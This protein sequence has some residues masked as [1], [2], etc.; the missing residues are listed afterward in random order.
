MELFNSKIEKNIEIL[1]LPIRVRPEKLQD[2]VGQLHLLGEKKPLRKIIESD[3]IP[4]MVFYGPPGCGKTALA[5]II[6]NMTKKKFVSLNAVT[7]T[8]SD[9]RDVLKEARELLKLE[10]KGTIL[11]LD[12]IS[13]FNKLQ[14]DALLKD[15]EEGTITLICATIHNPYFYINTPLLSRSLVF[16]F[17]PLSQEE[18]KKIIERALLD[19]RGLGNYK[20]KIT[21]DAIE[22]I[23]KKSQGDARKALNTLEFCVLTSEK[24]KDGYIVV[25]MDKT[26]EI[27][28]KY[29]IYDRKEDAHYDTISA[30]IK[31]MRGSDPDSALYYLA[32]M[33]LSGE[34]PRFI[35]RRMLIFA[36]EDIGNADPR[37]LI[38]ANAC[39]QAIEVVGMPE[40][41]IIL[42]QTV[43]YLS[44][45]PKSNS[46]YIAIENA[47]KDIETEREEEVPNH[48]KGTGYKGAEKLGRG[49]GYKYPHDYQGHYVVQKYRESEKKFY[50]PQDI[51]Y[52]SKIKKFLEEIE[53]I[54][55]E[56]KE[57]RNKTKN[58]ESKG[59]T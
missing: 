31:S 41:R 34:D 54:K 40:A 28:D 35:A 53:K 29:F 48:L 55:N 30:F 49:K 23:C 16:E 19:K 17:K 22:Y 9:V 11:F 47:I 38:L 25:N 24:E 1:P 12:E 57:N 7:A 18:I 36:S 52:E 42:A 26:K 8:T 45:A 58:K 6:A 37:A 50:F 56:S 5:M 20:I 43:I 14:Q 3:R 13:H 4:S 21:Q 27:L 15:V 39:Y 33:I 32:K 10:G 46:A 59:T 44:T 2:F 51:G